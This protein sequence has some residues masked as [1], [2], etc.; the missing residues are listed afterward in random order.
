MPKVAARAA[1]KTVIFTPVFMAD[2]P[3]D[4]RTRAASSG[5][6][7]FKI[8]PRGIKSSGRDTCGAY[9][10]GVYLESGQIPPAGIGD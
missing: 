8:P 2:L 7:H 9:L 5:S 4:V 10:W 3:Y 1:A 6:L